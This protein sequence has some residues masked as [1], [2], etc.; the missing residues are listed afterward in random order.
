MINHIIEIENW[1]KLAKPNPTGADICTQIGCHYE[2]V[3]E[4]DGALQCYSEADCMA[5]VFKD[6]YRN[7]ED[8]ASYAADIDPL[9]LL[10]ALCDQIVTAVG[11]GQL[12]GFDMPNA[13]AE[14]IRSNNSKI[15]D[16]KF[17]YDANG[18]MQKPEGHYVKPELK[19]FLGVK[20]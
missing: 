2:D 11:V 17:V 14:V 3:G 6:A 5:D 8:V 20:S 16:G 18:K 19:Q 13:L 15:V 10:D 1:F 4:M 12:M 9:A 7:P